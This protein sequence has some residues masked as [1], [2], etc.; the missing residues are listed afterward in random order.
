MPDPLTLIGGVASTIQILD[1]L[2]K[3][4]SALDT[5]RTQWLTSDIALLSLTSQLGA[6]SAAL[7][8]IH[9]WM[10]SG[11]AEVHHQLAMDLSTSISCCE[12]LATRVYRGISD[13]QKAPGGSMLSIA[14]ARFV[15]R[16]SGIG[17]VQ[18][19]IDRQVAVLTLLLA[20]CNRWVDCCAVLL[21]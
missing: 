1:I 20:A 5:L 9:E 7:S 12:M 8:K 4:I 19:M 16:R 17:E 18:G 15:F 3:A 2:T 11:S 6:L 21:E 13:L 10:Q 14:K